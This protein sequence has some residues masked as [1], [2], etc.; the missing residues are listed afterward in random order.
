MIHTSD[1]ALALDQGG[2]SRPDD[3]GFD[4]SGTRVRAPRY[5]V[6]DIYLLA[7]LVAVI[8]YLY[9]VDRT[10]V[11]L[12]PDEFASLGIARFLS[13]GEFNMLVA[14]TYRPLPGAMLVPWT[15]LLDDPELIVRF[16]LATNAVVAGATMFVLVPLLARLTNFDRGGV[17]VVSGVIA[18]LPASLEATAHLWAEP[19]VTLTFLGSLAAM[20][21]FVE[22]PAMG[23]LLSSIG[24]SVVGFTS[25]GRLL[26]FAVLIGLLAVVWSLAQGH[27]GLASCAAVTAVLG[28]A[29]SA[30]IQRW[31]VSEVW[32]LPGSRNSSGAIWDRL[33]NPVEV[34]DAAAGQIWYQLAASALVVGF[35]VVELARRASDKVDVARRR[36]ALVVLGLTVPLAIVSFVF[37]SDVSR[38]DHVLYGRYT[39]AVVW[40][41]LGVG[42]SWMFFDHSTMTRRR[43]RFAVAALIAVL[44]DLALLVH[45][46]HSE[47]VGRR[48]VTAMIAGI[49]W[50]T[51]DGRVHV[52]WVTAFT[53]AVAGVLYSA[54]RARQTDRR[55]W[56]AV[57]VMMVL[58]AG[59]RTWTVQR[60]DAETSVVGR[61]ARAVLDAPGR[62]P[63][64]T[65]IGVVLTPNDYGPS[66][67]RSAQIFSAL[68][69][70]YYLPEY[71]F[72]FDNGPS[73]DVGPY[74]FAVNNDALLTRDG[75]TILWTH[76]DFPISLWLEPPRDESES[77]SDG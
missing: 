44:A 67:I 51:N 57:I 31:I 70:Q 28:L 50:L 14:S 21:R 6:R 42:A 60:S 69:L 20:L 2:V 7:V 1:S 45:Q 72:V 76:P 64:G 3:H 24:W 5:L 54:A 40:P 49:L 61:G 66:I 33:G 74:V 46:L 34:L 9:V 39:D 52:L 22:H 4:V 41:V 25:H 63:L 59:V 75:G 26:P 11:S 71:R 38:A 23:P 32:E 15:L 8:R 12:S 56:A 18:V 47:Q 19:M 16:G 68:S 29:I 62:P 73:D 43:R 77:G 10:A 30:L 53:L 35:G 37:M 65:E 58:A 17:L 13:G 36:D 48:G 27:R 55:I